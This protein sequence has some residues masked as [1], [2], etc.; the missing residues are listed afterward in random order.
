MRRELG[1]LVQPSPR[2]LAWGLVL[3][4]ACAAGILLL[5]EALLWPVEGQ[6]AAPWWSLLPLFA[7]AEMVVIHLPTTRSSYSYG[8]REIPA[9]TGLA[10]LP[11]HGY[12]AAYVLG[13]GLAVLLWWR[14]RGLKLGFNLAMFSLEAVLGAGVY[15]TILGNGDETEP[16]GWLAALAAVV[17]SDLV[18]AAAMAAAMRITEGRHDP[19]ALR[20]VF[21]SSMPAAV[22]N[23]CLALLLVIL[24]VDRPSALALLAVVISIF[25]LAYRLYRS[26][27]TGY[28]RLQLLYRFVG[29]TGR[30]AELQDA[31]MS[32]LVEA[33]HV[34]RAERAELVLLP[35]ADEPGRRLSLHEGRQV[36]SEPL[37]TATGGEVTDWWGP[38]VGGAPVL[39]A[40][41]A[42][43]ARPRTAGRSATPSGEPRDGIAVPLVT[44]DRVEGVLLVADRT[45]SR[46]TFG[47]Q[48]LELFQTLAAH[49]A[50]ALDKARLVDSLR[51]VAEERELEA[52]QDALTGLPNRRAFT[53][54]VE[55]AL[56]SGRGGV[57]LLMDLDDFK[58]VNDT[59]GHAAGDQLL[60]VTGQRLQE[61]RGDAGGPA[62]TVAR[63]GGDEFAVL[64]PGATVDEAVRH[65]RAL[66]DA[67][68]RP[69]PL[70]DI[71]L[72]ATVS[73]GVA[74]IPATTEDGDVLAHA[75]TAMY[76]AKSSGTGVE[77]YLPEGTDDI[78]RRL[79]LAGDLPRAID[80]RQ[81][82]IWCQPQAEVCSGRVTGV[83][84][85]LRWRHP[86]HGYVPPTEIVA[87]AERTGLL[88]RLTDAII[89]QSL[90]HRAAWAA[91]GRPIDIS[92]NVTP[93]DLSDVA[94]PA[95]VARLLEATGTPPSV[96]TLEIT[97]SGVMSDPERALVVLDALSAREVRLSIDDFGTGH[98]SLAYLER[99]PV[100]E[101]K[102]DRS[103]V[104]RLEREAS[105][106]VVMRSTITLAH[107][108]GLRVVAEGVESDVAHGRVAALGVE[109]V[110][111]YHL[112]RPMPADQVLGWLEAYEPAA[113]AR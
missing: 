19:A 1:R 62:G 101:V 9:V 61:P 96:L 2:L 57:V 50:V 105:D 21:R 89:R 44:D 15:H 46:E 33:Q 31:V 64:L 58:D 35:V 24:L 52:R 27:A 112:A 66:L 12:V 32:V 34:L 25:V 73:I 49:A 75:D 56:A 87:V 39:L 76:V 88:R 99:L 47:Q 93:R 83:E 11:F 29:S 16:R 109:L 23:T 68:T 108:L 26:L 3:V 48:D 54:G 30:S 28:G 53:E 18:S 67:V 13:A 110:Q 20:E 37:V 72:K 90:E 69:V 104:Q 78:R 103:F 7:A 91:A 10:L 97:E 41:E 22:V 111:G 63:L 113:H 36:T 95:T 8:L 80:E 79:A 102:I 6:A 59:L 60:Q 86:V 70:R 100:Q 71:T 84:A 74:P 4:M 5:L 45:F 82:E 81:L 94:L 55:A 40:N 43:K 77:V 107:H 51:R 92:V 42:A 98:S 17:V 65:A 106:S 85:L 14:Q 38:A